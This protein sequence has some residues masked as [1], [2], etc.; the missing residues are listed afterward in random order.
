MQGPT[1]ETAAWAGGGSSSSDPQ[2]A[3]VD[4]QNAA[5]KAGVV[6]AS[7]WLHQLQQGA[8][9]RVQCAHCTAPAWPLMCAA[10][11]HK[12]LGK[13]SGSDR[14]VKLFPSPSQSIEERRKSFDHLLLEHSSVHSRQLSESC[15]YVLSLNP[16]VPINMLLFNSKEVN[17]SHLLQIVTTFPSSWSY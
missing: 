11:I 5:A 10:D 2:A 9:H 15:T 1:P 3:Q 7:L 17:P 4:W 8:A 14:E 16:F 12:H 13:I 6:P